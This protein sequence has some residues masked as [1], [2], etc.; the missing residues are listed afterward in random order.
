MLIMTEKN[1]EFQSSYI[2][3]CV[4]VWEGAEKKGILHLLVLSN[5]PKHR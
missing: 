4:D 2:N 5:R 1:K 3:M